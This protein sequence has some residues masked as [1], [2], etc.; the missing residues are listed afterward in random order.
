MVYYRLYFLN[1][2]SGHIDGF[3]EYH[4]TDDVAATER[5]A[6]YCGDVPLELWSGRRKIRHF[7]PGHRLEQSV[8]TH[9]N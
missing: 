8:R 4:A 2:H 9:V 1:P 7:P 3:E 6:E 5:A